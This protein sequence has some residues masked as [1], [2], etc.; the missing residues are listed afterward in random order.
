M[1]IVRKVFQVMFVKFLDLSN[2]ISESYHMSEKYPPQKSL[3]IYS[4]K[5]KNMWI[6]LL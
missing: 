5:R 3:P 6:N 4:L 2:T 1:I